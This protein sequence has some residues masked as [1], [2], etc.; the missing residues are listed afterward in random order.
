L[1]E[2]DGEY[3]ALK[4]KVAEVDKIRVRVYDILRK[5]KQRGQPVKLQGAEL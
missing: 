4:N 3:Q 5:E 1:R 2:L